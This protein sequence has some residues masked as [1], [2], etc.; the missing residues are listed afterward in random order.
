MTKKKT[1]KKAHKKGTKN[2][3]KPQKKALKPIDELSVH[4]VLDRSSIAMENFEYFIMS[5]PFV[6]K[7]PSL[8]KK[9]EMVFDQ[10]YAFY[11]KAG[12][13][14]VKFDKKLKKATIV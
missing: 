1:A 7:T 4:E 11:Q 2:I 10:L 14:S 6:R 3:L 5:H 8:K 9:S 13:E 12:E